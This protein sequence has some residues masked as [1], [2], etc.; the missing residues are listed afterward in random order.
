MSGK[1]RR[2]GIYTSLARWTSRFRRVLAGEVPCAL[3][4]NQKVKSQLGSPGSSAHN[5]LPVGPR[6]QV[7]TGVPRA[8]PQRC[9]KPSSAGREIPAWG[10]VREA[11][12]WE[13]R[14]EARSCIG[15]RGALSEG[16]RLRWGDEGGGS[17]CGDISLI[18]FGFRTDGMAEKLAAALRKPEGCLYG[19]ENR[20]WFYFIKLLKLLLFK[21]TRWFSGVEMRFRNWCI[22]P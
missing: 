12:R 17:F 13:A 4:W 21:K 14:G 7:R 9:G 15:A 2:T 3:R 19:V 1:R 6:C 20:K 18:F 22:A 5:G 11:R 10:R 8:A 16:A